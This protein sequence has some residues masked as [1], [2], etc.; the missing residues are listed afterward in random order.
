MS[1]RQRLA[2][3]FLLHAVAQG[4]L[5]ARLP[6]L[7]QALSINE[8]VLGLALLGQPAGA[9]AGF[10]LASTLIERFGTRP[11][12]LLCIPGMALGTMLM[13]LSGSAIMLFAAFAAFGVVFGIANIAV[14]VEADR[15]EA[16]SGSRLMNTCHGVWSAGLLAASLLG[17]AMRGFAVPPLLH[18]GL[19]ALIVCLGIV[20]VAAG[21]RP[22]PARPHTGALTRRARLS[23]PTL[24]TLLLLGYSIASAL[25]EGALRNWSV[26]FMRDSFTAP[27]WVDTLTLPA[28][29]VAQTAGRLLSDRAVTRWGPVRLA[30]GLAAIALCGLVLVVVSPSLW[31]AL[32]GF[33]LIGLGV[34]A[35]FPLSASAAARQGD[36]PAS[37]N[38]AA[39]TMAQQVLMLGA[40]ALLGLV[41]SAVSIR[42]T[43]AILIPPLLV[44][45]YLAR[46][47]A[48]EPPP[49]SP[50][51]DR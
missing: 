27:D 2:I 15:L 49:P 6:D 42:A 11:A 12:M 4:G 8:A 26:I 9:I 25:L 23:L 16:A 43:F 31:V 7:Q 35:A 28:F 3:V 21:L 20:L 34:S 51:A 46:Y 36:R 10:L 1:D 30:R 38:V 41:A 18:F 47:L 37:Q 39:L 17:T 29:L 13:A 48:T 50:L 33:A 19:V 22:A 24:M 45:I 5:Y 44:A 40:P 32:C 14:N